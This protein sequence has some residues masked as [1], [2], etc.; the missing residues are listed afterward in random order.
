MVQL[1]GTGSYRL[2]VATPCLEALSSSF[3]DFE[4][5]LNHDPFEPAEEDIRVHGIWEAKRRAR[6]DTLTTAADAIRNGWGAGPAECY[7]RACEN[8][9]LKAAL[10]RAILGWDIRNAEP[11]DASELC[12]GNA[13]EG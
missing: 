11:A 7:R 5:V 8:A 3:R 1:K 4:L 12:G 13:K 10:E 9:G 2:V 6:T